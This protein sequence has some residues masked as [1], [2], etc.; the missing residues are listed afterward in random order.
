MQIQCL[1]NLEDTLRLSVSHQWF[2]T[3]E[4]LP[5]GLFKQKLQTLVDNFLQ[6]SEYFVFDGSHPD[7]S[8]INY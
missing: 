6:H 3:L 4:H 7:V 2:L 1:Q 8:V 5:V